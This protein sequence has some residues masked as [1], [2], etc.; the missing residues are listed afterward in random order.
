MILYGKRF[1][2]WYNQ[3]ENRVLPN[4]MGIITA[5]LFK[6]RDELSFRNIRV[7]LWPVILVFPLSIILGNLRFYDYSVAL[8]GFESYELTFFLLGSGWFILALLPK[9]LIMPLHCIAALISAV[10]M[11]LSTFM[12]MGFERFV[13]YMLFKFFIGLCA[14]CSFYLFCFVLNNV[15]RLFGMA[16]IQLYY[17]FFFASWE[18][19]S[20]VHVN[21]WTGIIA[22]AAYFAVVF[23]CHTKQHETNTENDGRKSGV[24]Y[25]IG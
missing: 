1:L 23:L 3:K 25:I 19:S 5:K 16:L 4:M 15:E 2:A 12:P 6:T 24:L 20:I 14:A 13:V 8:T 17:S 9:R 10:L 22:I 18:T 21:S 7:K 11:P